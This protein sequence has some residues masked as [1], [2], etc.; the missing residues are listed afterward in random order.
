M[1]LKAYV[2]AYDDS[3]RAV[4]LDPTHVKS[5]GR[6]GQ[7]CYY[8]GKVKQAKI[9]FINALKLDPTNVLFLEYIKKTNERLQR[10]K[11]E[12]VE[13]IERRIMFTDLDE[14]GFEEHSYRVP[15]KELHL[16]QKVIQD[17]QQKRDQVLNR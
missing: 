11:S 1:K 15:V 4:Q 7:A 6:R 14:I 12:A 17:L 8:L 9:D 3:N 2:K 13:K 10:L 16:D 5:I